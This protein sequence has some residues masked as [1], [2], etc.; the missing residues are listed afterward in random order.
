MPRDF[1]TLPRGLS[2]GCIISARRSDRE[3]ASASYLYPIRR[4]D[5]HSTSSF[6]R[7]SFPNIVRLLLFP[8]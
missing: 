6:S 2:H 1:W 5:P 3:L 4:P 8:P 7:I